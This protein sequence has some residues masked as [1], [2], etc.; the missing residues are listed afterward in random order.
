MRNDKQNQENG[1]EE[2]GMSPGRLRFKVLVNF[3]RMV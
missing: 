2:I 1:L 3:C